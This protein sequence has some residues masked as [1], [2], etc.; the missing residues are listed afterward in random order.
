MP[1]CPH[2][3]DLL[4]HQHVVVRG[5][6]RHPLVLAPHV[7]LG[8][9]VARRLLVVPVQPVRALCRQDACE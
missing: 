1:S 2:L 3:D 5:A 4:E 9:G 8:G 6:R 7:V